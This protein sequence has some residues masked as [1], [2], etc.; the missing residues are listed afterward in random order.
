MLVLALTA[1]VGARNISFAN[2][3]DGYL[4]V[5]AEGVSCTG[6]G[7]LRLQRSDDSAAVAGTARSDAQKRVG[8]YGVFA[9]YDE[10]VHDSGLFV[11]EFNTGAGVDRLVS[12]MWSDWIAEGEAEGVYGY[13]YAPTGMVFART[14]GDVAA[15]E[16]LMPFLSKLPL[17]NLAT[18]YNYTMFDL[19]T[20]EPWRSDT[21]HSA[22]PGMLP[23]LHPVLDSTAD[24]PQPLKK[25]YAVR[26]C[27]DATENQCCLVV[28]NGENNQAVNPA[29]FPTFV[30]TKL[31][32]ENA[33]EELKLRW[34]GRAFHT[35]YSRGLPDLK[36]YT[37]HVDDFMRLYGDDPDDNVIKALKLSLQDAHK[38]TGQDRDPSNGENELKCRKVDN[39]GE[40][41]YWA[42]AWLEH[43]YTA[44][45]GIEE[46]GMLRQKTPEYDGDLGNA[47]LKREYDEVTAGD[48]LDDAIYQNN[49][50]Y[51]FV[52][53]HNC[54]AQPG[55]HCG[56]GYLCNNDRSED[57]L[58]RFQDEGREVDSVQFPFF[59]GF[60]EKG[61]WRGRPEL[62][63]FAGDGV[64]PAVPAENYTT[65]SHVLDGEGDDWYNEEF[66]M[67]ARLVYTGPDESDPSEQGAN[68]LPCAT[69]R[70]DGAYKN[71]AGDF[72]RACGKM[73]ATQYEWLVAAMIQTHKYPDKDLHR[74]ADDDGFWWEAER[75][76]GPRPCTLAI[77]KDKC[78]MN[79]REN[80]VRLWDI[81]S[82]WSLN[83][84][85]FLYKGAEEDSE[86]YK[87][88]KA[89]HEIDNVD[90]H[91]LHYGENED[92]T[93]W[94]MPS[95]K[96]TTSHGTS[97]GTSRTNIH[98][99]AC[100]LPSKVSNANAENDRGAK[101]NAG[102]VGC[103][104]WN[105]Y[106]AARA[107]FW[108]YQ[109]G[110]LRAINGDVD[111]TSPAGCDLSFGPP[112]NYADAIVNKYHAKSREYD[113][114]RGTYHKQGAPGVF[115]CSE[116]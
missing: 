31:D 107:T 32:T 50:L 87:N 28:E 100:H 62:L 95:A 6:G 70:R 54:K 114:Y 61:R 82:S 98:S 65:L 101:F 76:I 110:T 75:G 19:H 38:L 35:S 43:F 40:K 57:V 49:Y 47:N 24:S 26:Q 56:F 10:V 58:Q 44:V 63:R 23:A 96:E 66:R 7:R 45:V 90:L 53:D 86:Y 68:E 36:T 20:R 13:K 1:A 5:V 37:K 2:Y 77:K 52:D 113:W 9:S 16:A 81:D 8:S 55:G 71:V 116:Y 109:W 115:G 30:K 14:D 72:T 21:G 105:N 88:L 93:R 34:R 29:P 46:A 103:A 33:V 67:S 79:N 48:N 22:F 94:S 41:S 69:T 27:P 108:P 80:R 78:Y 85:E 99:A 74:G 51:N 112:C 12:D 102:C 64:T 92:G 25:Q 60:C 106:F 3:G 59:R 97:D 91:I 4:Q 17:D 11:P 84:N 42:A 83:T 89:L 111:W 18:E 104:N 15:N 39:V 73:R